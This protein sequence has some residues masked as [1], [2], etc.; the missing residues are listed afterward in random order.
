M[1]PLSLPDLGFFCSDVC[2]QVPRNLPEMQRLVALL[3]WLSVGVAQAPPRVA[4]LTS[5][6]LRSFAYFR[7]EVIPRYYAN[8]W[9]PGYEMFLSVGDKESMNM[10]LLD[11]AQFRAATAS[12]GGVVH[13]DIMVMPY[14]M[15][16]VSKGG[17]F[18]THFCPENKTNHMSLLMPAHKLSSVYASMIREE[19]RSGKPYEYVVRYRPD[20]VFVR[21]LPHVSE[22][23]AFYRDSTT[24]GRSG[25]ELRMQYGGLVPPTGEPGEKGIPPTMADVVL[26]DD[27]FGVM[28]RSGAEGF[29]LGA[30]KAYSKCYD[31]AEWAKVC[32]MKEA[33]TKQVI[34]SRGVPCCPARLAASEFDFIIRDC[35]YV[36]PPSL[37]P[38]LWTA[39]PLPLWTA[40]P[41]PMRRTSADARFPRRRSACS[42]R[43]TGTGSRRGARARPRCSNEA[44]RREHSAGT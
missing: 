8:F 27:Q 26:W 4:V 33:I 42:Q 14:E 36:R 22:M 17:S 16:R 28:S 30:S 44:H 41:S 35:G 9:K 2:L 10:R 18:G 37:T 6:N 32:G 24:S 1:R 19:R 29:F 20:M 15:T 7:D 12:Y 25:V 11:E 3:G 23:F 38:S 21:K 31:F 40:T 43:T 13:T 39:H 5:G 34:K